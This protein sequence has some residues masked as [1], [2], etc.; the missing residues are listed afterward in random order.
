MGH[1]DENKNWVDD[2]ED[3][4]IWDFTD[5]PTEKEPGAPPSGQEAEPPVA[6]DEQ[7][8]EPEEPAASKG[9]DEKSP[10]QPEKK[11]EEQEEETNAEPE[12]D[13]DL[14]EQIRKLNDQVASL[15]RRMGKSTKKS[16]KLPDPIED[17]SA[18]KSDSFDTIEDYEDARKAWEIDKR[19][20]DQV[21]KALEVAPS[22]VEDQ[23]RQS[24]VEELKTDGPKYYKDFVEVV[25]DNTLPIT[26]EILD[27]VRNSDNEIVTPADVLYFLGKNKAET[28]RISRLNPIQ[29]AREIVKIETKIEIA[30]AAAPRKKEHSEHSN[31]TAPIKPTRTSTVII[32][33]DPEKMS[34]SEYEKWRLSASGR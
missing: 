28:V 32:T 31:A 23:E 15:H 19:V 22:E 34:Q 9:E 4:E 11:P 33:K 16:I 20:N 25:T 10:E 18:P 17:E 1:Y 3:P 5:K 21:R 27:A 30:K 13:D 12:A 24:F 7:E 6:V 14:K 8:K 26:V 2:P 29:V